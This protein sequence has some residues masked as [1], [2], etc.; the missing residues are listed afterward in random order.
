MKILKKSISQTLRI[1]A[2]RNRRTFKVAKESIFSVSR[3]V[4]MTFGL[5]GF[6]IGAPGAALAASLPIGADVLHG[7]I[8][9]ENSSPNTLRILQ[10]SQSAIVNW[11]SFDIG[12]GALVDIVQ[13]N[14]DA[15]ML[16]RVV[17]NNLSEI[18]GSLNANGH[19][20]LINP[21]GILFGSDAQ[22]NVHAL[23]ASSLDIADS[24]FLSGNIAFDGDSEAR[25]MNLGTINADQF[26]ALIGG[27][28]GNAGTIMAEGGS[29]GLLASDMT[30]K[31]GEASGGDISLDISGLLNGSAMQD[32][33]IDV[34]NE[35]G[36]G[37][38]VLVK[39]KDSVVA[40]GT[41]STISNGGT[42]GNGGSI[43]FFS[44]NSATWEP[45]SIISAQGGISAGNGGFVELSGLKD[46]QFAGSNISTLAPNGETG[47]FLIDP[48]DITISS[49]ATTNLSLNGNSYDS[50]STTTVLNVDDLV[51]AL[52]S[53]NI[54]VTTVND[55]YDAPNGGD[56]TVAASI[57]SSSGND[58]TLIASDQLTSSHG[59]DI[60]LTGNLNL[61][62]GPGGIQT[63]GNIN[64]GSN[65]LTSNSGGSA[66]YVGDVTAGNLSLATTETGSI[67]QSTKFKGGELNL[68]TNNGNVEVTAT[69]G[70]LTIASVNIGTG[71]ATIKASSGVINDAATDSIIDF[72]ANS[73]TLVGTSIGNT[74]P[75]EFGSVA[76]LDLTASSG[77]ISSN[78]AAPTVTS[79]TASAV[80]DAITFENSA[81][82]LEIASLNSGGAVTLTSSGAITQTGA[83]SN[84]GQSIILAAGLSNDITL[85]NPANDFGTITITSANNVSLRDLSSFTLNSI[86]DSEVAGNLT[87]QTAGGLAFALPAIT[88]GSS[89]N[90]TITSTGAVTDS[91]SLIIPGT[92]TILASGQN[93]TLDDSSNNFGTIGVTGSDV[94][95]QDSDAVDL[96]AATVSGTFDITSSG[97]IS[98]S[99]ALVITGVSTFN[100]SAGTDASIILNNAANVFTGTVTF[101]TDAG[102]SVTVVDTTAL[103][104]EAL[105]V[106]ALSVT[107]SGDVTDSGTLAITGATTIDAGTGNITLNEVASTFGSLALTGANVAV[108]ENDATELA[109]STV[110]GTLDIISGGAITNSGALAITGA[111]TF[112]NTD[113]TNDA[114]TLNNVGNAFTGT[115]GFSTDSGSAVTVVDTT[116]LDL[117][118]LTAASLSVTASG[119]VTDSG[120]LAI[121]GATTINA[122]TGNITLDEAASTF[123]A[124]A[125]TGANVA[126][127]ENAAMELAASTISGTASFDST[128]NAITDSGTLAIAGATTIDAGT[129]DITL[130]EAA[131]TFGSLALTGANVAVTEN[132]ATELAVSTVSGTLDIISGGA[133]TN[134]GA[135][136][137]TG[138]STFTNTDG[139]NDAITLNNVGNAFTGTV[140]FSTDSGSAVTVVDTTALD[141]QALTAAS[142]SVT[143]SG[144]V[145]DSGTLAIAGATTIDAGT[146]DITLNEA[147]ST[148]GS[149][150][151]TGA[152]VAVTE[153][154]ATE[155]AASTVSGTLDII[156]G[157]AIT[158]SGALAVTGASTFTNTDGTN[159]VITLNNVGNAFTGTVGFS[160]DSGSAVTVVDTTALD[161]QALTAAS[162]S[163]TAS[164]DVTDSGTLAIAG[165]TTINAGTGNIT[166]DE[167][168]STFGA[169][170]L[171]GAN[172]AVTENA[173]M[174][175][176]A[177]TISGTASFDSTDNAI[178]RQRN[179][180]DHWGNHHRRRN[181]EHYFERGR[182]DL[183]ER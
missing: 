117:Q 76:I 131:S 66:I 134:S 25:V 39:A 157:G 125:L 21:N 103:D 57:T 64:I 115:V 176:A 70:D 59:A 141:L 153:N 18:H 151:L 47:L 180:G 1:W 69:T 58:L 95:I 167:A 46:V 4:L 85:S 136:A 54:T 104:L 98:S 2:N 178:H 61:I 22:V 30:F 42:N 120:S 179:F 161:L 79:L 27:K 128:D 33:L 92:T 148:F 145:T 8:K 10:S 35:N 160:T 139:T 17:G 99:G 6:I 28:V 78:S 24:T 11:Q 119:D 94:S 9:L 162:L 133:I 158:N 7:Q 13:P 181:R 152:N 165:A 149:L 177:S 90:L 60:S 100:N 32:G 113:G 62:A 124:L 75:I 170:A 29:V 144:D 38:D 154:D 34:S 63:I 3:T 121:A 127:T 44:D 129:A 102:S 80:S 43:V 166:L 110:S 122:G 172:V 118:A 5:V 45:D 156:S 150:A 52:A 82:G 169:L 173:A 77:S 123:G 87:L 55:N 50:A 41:S 93:I 15:A 23:I 182:V 74:R 138:A 114:I 111:S 137:I 132:D 88:L 51:A 84:N 12:E 89:D 155:L 37:G 86:S 36:T 105:T 91:G 183:S 163:V 83:I 101:T 65:T 68:T 174:E 126:V 40:T 112:T 96:A 146:A 81:G 130:N 14:I 107:A 31:I 175:L 53:N 116:A 108:T 97:V 48:V 49:A 71:S 16:S 143:A 106:V 109:A 56:L 159:D 168:A 140:G 67:I 73:A 19:L 72:V 20:Y 26:A 164:G 142:L 171:T 135:L 147:A